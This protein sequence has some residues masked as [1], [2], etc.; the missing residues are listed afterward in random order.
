MSE[1]YLSATS[2]SKKLNI[3]ASDLFI[4]L[5]KMNLIV[6]SNDKWELTK[7]GIEMGGMTKKDEKFGEYII[8]PE[9]LPVD[10]ILSHVT[11]SNDNLINASAIAEKIKRSPQKVN[12]LFSELGWM[13][14]DDKRGWH[15]TKL[16]KIV[17]GKQKEHSDSGKLYVLW[18][19]D[20]FHNKSFQETLIENQILTDV[21]STIK[22]KTVDHNEL[23]F[24]EKF[25]ATHRTSDG[26][27]VRSRAEVIIDNFL[28]NNQ[29]IHAYERKVPIEEE[30]YSDFY[31]PMGEKVY[32]EFWGKV[33]D[34]Q[35]DKRKNI[36]ID[37]YKKNGLNL[38]ELFDKDL[39]NIDDILPGKLLK[40]KI[41]GYS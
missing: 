23:S 34:E 16:G 8:W 29:I 13:E 21:D 36:K 7:E 9:N 6:R 28:Y 11:K 18:P 33:G 24:R 3:D 15:I 26:H 30:V 32:I 4:A 19:D 40:Y 41:K 37:I 12:L 5:Q 1:K 38:I 27:M 10:L 2:I 14:K 39:T 17:G 22:E 25:P 31:I 35:Y 20:I